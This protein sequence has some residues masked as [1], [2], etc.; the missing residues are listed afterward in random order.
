MARTHYFYT[1]LP[2]YE[3]ENLITI[4]QKEFDE[5][6]NDNFSEAELKGYEK[7]LEA[8]AAVEVSEKL[9]DLG[10]D[11]FFFEA[12]DENEMRQFFDASQ[13][14]ICLE[15]LPFFETNCFQVSFLRGLLAKIDHVLID[16]GGVEPICYK[17]SYLDY[18]LPFLGL[19]S[20]IKR[21]E[22]PQVIGPVDTVDYLAIDV[23]QEIHRLK[24]K[25]LLE[26]IE[27]ELNSRSERQFKIFSVMKNYE[28]EPFEIR[29]RAGLIPK[30][31]GDGLESL[32][33]YLKRL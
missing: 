28:L 3:L 13:S 5:Q 29:K 27:S 6:L 32:K 8:M 16:Q 15:N 20:L 2:D 19:E 10:F 24:A 7:K 21:E 12:Q 30:D 17:D 18:L 26:Q 14:V 31:F 9:A 33:F 25:G 22:T 4:Y 23:Y 11:D 1:Q